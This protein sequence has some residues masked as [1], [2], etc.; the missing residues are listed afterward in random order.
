LRETSAAIGQ[1][2]S[3]VPMELGGAVDPP[4]VVAEAEPFEVTR[5]TMR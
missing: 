1:L 5:R 4:V 3:A 2:A